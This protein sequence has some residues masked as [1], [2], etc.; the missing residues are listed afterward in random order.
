[1]A[2]VALV[3]LWIPETKDVSIAQ[4]EKGVL[5]G[6]EVV[7]SD[8]D[9]TAPSKTDDITVT[10]GDKQALENHDLVVQVV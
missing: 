3:T 9:E 1:M 4:I 8:S 7:G 2:L 10:R 6:V 5:Y